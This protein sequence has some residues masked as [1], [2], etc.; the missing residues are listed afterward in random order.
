M[1]LKGI[2]KTLAFAALLLCSVSVW[3]QAKPADYP[4]T[5]HVA[6]SYLMHAGGVKDGEVFQEL[7]VLIDG[8]KLQLEAG[9]KYGLLELGN[10]KAKV[11]KS[12]EKQGHFREQTYEI[13]FPDNKTETFKVVG[14]SE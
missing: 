4:L 13:L 1:V 8:K 7:D 9:S 2:M 10:Y 14:E 3:S 11:K 6:R 12:I 5:V